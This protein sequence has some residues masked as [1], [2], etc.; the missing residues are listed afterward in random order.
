MACLP[1]FDKVAFAPLPPQPLHNYLAG[2]S[3]PAAHLLAALLAPPPARRIS[4]SA[5]LAHPWLAAP[6][7]A[8]RP[9][10]LSSLATPASVGAGRPVLR[11]F[12]EDNATRIG[13]VLGWADN[14]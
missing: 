14:S 9:P 7:L 2:L 3:E 12:N 10:A 8:A 5:A 4:A 13:E 11:R 1:D 6:P